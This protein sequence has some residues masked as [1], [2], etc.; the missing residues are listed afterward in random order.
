MIANRVFLIGYM[1]SGK[2]TIG[3][4]L[5]KKMQYSFVDLDKY[6]EQKHSG[7]IS[8]IFSQKG[9]DI[10]RKMEREA[11]E[12]LIAI[13]NVVISLG[14]GTPC[15][16]DNMKVIREN[17]VSVYLKMPASALLQRLQN[18]KV[19][20]PLLKGLGENEKLEFIEQQLGERE[21]YYL[22][23]DLIFSGFNLSVDKLS[24]ELGILLQN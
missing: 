3:K 1:G 19:E 21:N 17:G 24:E 22:G 16:F 14:G 18:A 8:D 6:I 23:A 2:S 11:L 7:C 5:A 9:E 20:R 4:K 10:F 12:E 15:F 13:D